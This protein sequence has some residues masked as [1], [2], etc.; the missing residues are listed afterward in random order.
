VIL[1]GDIESCFDQISHPWMLKHIPMDRKVLEKWLKA[2]YMEG[3]RLYPTEEG[4]PQGGIISPVL[5]NLVLDGL[6]T[7]ALEA[8]PLRRG[9]L[10][11]KINVVRYA[12]DCAPRR[13]RKEALMAA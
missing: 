6:E 10:R 2:G 13:R 7:A 5:A 3:Q 9:K 1:E 4:T 12:D 11:P 8:D